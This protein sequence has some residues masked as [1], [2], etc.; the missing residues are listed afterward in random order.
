MVWAQIFLSIVVLL[1][2][3]QGEG[4]SRRRGTIAYIVS[5]EPLYYNLMC[6]SSINAASLQTLVKIG[7]I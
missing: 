2:E 6:Y 5:Q 3:F 7:I 1:I 4:D